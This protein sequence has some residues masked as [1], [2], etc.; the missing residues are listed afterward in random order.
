MDDFVEV[1]NEN[2][3]SSDDNIFDNDGAIKKEDVISLDSLFENEEEVIDV[4]EEKQALEKIKQKR[5]TN[6]QI[7]LIIFLVVF[8]TLVYFFGYDFVE[9]FIKID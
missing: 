9:P 2:T 4:Y 5:I 3:E 6:I 8:A 1:L 7:G